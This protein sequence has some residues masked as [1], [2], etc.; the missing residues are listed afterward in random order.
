MI[1]F[2][3]Q[4]YYGQKVHFSIWMHVFLILIVSFSAV[5]YTHVS[6]YSPNGFLF[7]MAVASLNSLSIAFGQQI[8]GLNADS[9]LFWTH[10]K[11]RN[12]DTTIV[13]WLLSLLGTL[14]SAFGAAQYAQLGC[15]S[16]L[17]LLVIFAICVAIGLVFIQ[18]NSETGAK[19]VYRISTIW[20]ICLYMSLGGFQILCSFF[21]AQNIPLL[22]ELLK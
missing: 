6:A 13:Y 21:E 22:T 3:K 9:A 14:I 11:M 8:R 15:G 10:L 1:P 18:N 19:N 2:L 4:I 17:F 12:T 5:A 16:S 20:T 7:F